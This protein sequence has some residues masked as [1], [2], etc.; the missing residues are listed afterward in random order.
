[1][2]ANGPVRILFRKFQSY[3]RAPGLS[4]ESML[5]SYLESFK[6]LLLLQSQKLKLQLES[7]LE[8]FKV[9][10]TGQILTCQFR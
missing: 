6:E 1:M 2:G 5:E 9:D 8:S 7:Y 10:P 3:L 4:A